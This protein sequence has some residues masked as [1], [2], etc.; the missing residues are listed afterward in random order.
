[1]S[2]NI[3]DTMKTDTQRMIAVIE[4]ASI[5]PEVNPEKMRQLLDVQMTIMDRQA[6]IEFDQ[7]MAECQSEMSNLRILKEADNQQ[8]RSSYAK[9]ESICAAIKPVYTKHGFRLSFSEGKSETEGEI[10]VNCNVTHRQGHAEHYWIDLPT[11]SAGI[12]GKVNKTPV[13]AKGSTFS[14]GRRY[15]TLMIFDLATYDD[16]DANRPPVE[17]ITDDQVN[18]LYA[19]ADENGVM[20]PF[21]KWLRGTMKVDSIADI[22][23]AAFETVDK[24][25]DASIKAR[26]EVAE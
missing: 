25:L 26:R 2:K 4:S 10:R 14:Y 19:K 16:N 21:M 24:K 5:N 9:H 6:K 13:H 7:A 20:E 17:R 22:S 18:I 1:M 3:S 12:Q 11:D 23:V 15:L 8:T